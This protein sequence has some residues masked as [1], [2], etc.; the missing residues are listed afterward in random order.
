MAQG[1]LIV[2]EGTDGSGKGTQ[3]ALLT[4]ELTKRNIPYETMDFPRYGKSFFG[5]LAGQLL[6]GDFG[7]VDELAPQLA[8]LP[9]ACDRWLLKEDVHRWLSEGKIVISNRYTASS[10]VYHAAKLPKEKQHPFIDWLYKLEQEVIGMPKEDVA[11]YF[12]VPA[13]L[14]QKLV[15]SKDARSYLGDKKKDI[16]EENT[17][18]QETVEAL[19]LELATHRSGWKTIE[20][21]EGEILRSKEAIHKDI[22]DVLT[23]AA[24]L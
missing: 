15:E 23:T 21:M 6:A 24:V 20:C 10:A 14:S 12:H 11:M 8:V 5:D 7:G 22:L 19:Y 13:K 16:Y 18:M 9:F 3:L 1:K 17:A 2:L 4:A